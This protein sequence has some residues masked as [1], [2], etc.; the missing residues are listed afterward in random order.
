MCVCPPFGIRH[1]WCIVWR[2]GRFSRRQ[3]DS[4][5]ASVLLFSKGSHN[6]RDASSI[7]HALLSSRF[8]L[9][10]CRWP[11]YVLLDH[12]AVAGQACRITGVTSNSS[13]PLRFRFQRNLSC[14]SCPLRRSSRLHHPARTACL[15]YPAVRCRI[16]SWICPLFLGSC[17]LPST[18][19][20]KSVDLNTLLSRD[21]PSRPPSQGLMRSVAIP[22]AALPE[23]KMR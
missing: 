15:P 4:N 23:L 18:A 10:L 6:I 21:L 8:L 13:S 22:S 12:A 11:S 3:N 9:C 5:D 14:G 2:A 20:P 1:P 17:V 7:V 19:V 16:L